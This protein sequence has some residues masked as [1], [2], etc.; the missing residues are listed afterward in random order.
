[1]KLTLV[2]DLHCDF[3]QPKTP[4]IETELVIVAGDTSNGLHGL[5]MLN[6]WKR[7]G[8]DVF[9]VDGNH[10]HYS[11]VVQG[12][13]Q[14]DTERQ[15]YAGLDAQPM[16]RMLGDSHYLIG[17]N[18]W[19]EVEDERHWYGYMNDSRY[20]GIHASEM[21][22][23]AVRHAD[24]VDHHL[25]LMPLGRK[26]LVVTHTAPCEA[27]LDPQ[28]LGSDGNVYYYNPLMTKVLKRHKDNIALWVH[29]HTHASV[30]VVVEGVRIVTN[31]RGYPGENPDWK[32]LVLEV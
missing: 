15:F 6:K 20:S 9:A 1:M 11:N 24:F 32:P 7:K 14:A 10:E 22:R 8:H 19:Y 30:D 29:G 26:A 18:G 21:N 5:K 13:S 23:L 2:S 12:R 25:E 4:P 17:C 3:P 27:S 16:H 28:Y 31:P